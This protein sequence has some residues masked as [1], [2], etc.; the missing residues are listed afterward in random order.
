MKRNPSMNVVVKMALAHKTVEATVIC[1]AGEWART[2]YDASYQW[3][4]DLY[5][6]KER[7][8]VFLGALWAYGTTNKRMRLDSAIKLIKRVAM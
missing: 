8:N 5:K 1:P 2:Y 6:D 7:V 3:Y 4:L